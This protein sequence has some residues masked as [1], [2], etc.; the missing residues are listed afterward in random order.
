MA[1]PPPADMSTI[2][3]INAVTVHE[4]QIFS[5]KSIDLSGLMEPGIDAA[6]SVVQ[7]SHA[8]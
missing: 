6:G 8:K 4:S 7:R 1:V 5:L 3:G 2:P